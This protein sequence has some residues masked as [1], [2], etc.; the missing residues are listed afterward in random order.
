MLIGQ[1]NKGRSGMGLKRRR[2]KNSSCPDLTKISKNMVD[3]LSHFD[4][5]KLKSQAVKPY[6]NVEVLMFNL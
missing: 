3:Q 4:W 2:I 6:I 5:S 1:G